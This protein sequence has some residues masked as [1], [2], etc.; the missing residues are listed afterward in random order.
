MKM[1]FKL[2]QNS[3]MQVPLKEIETDNLEQALFEALDACGCS[4][5]QS[6]E[7]CYK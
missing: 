6:T 4:L 2:W 5:T 3:D 7:E 1:K